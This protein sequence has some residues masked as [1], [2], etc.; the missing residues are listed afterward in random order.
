M[1]VRRSWLR[2]I[3]CGWPHHK[4]ERLWSATRDIHLP[5]LRIHQVGRYAGAGKWYGRSMGVPTTYTSPIPACK[6]YKCTAKCGVRW[7][8]ALR[9]AFR[10]FPSCPSKP[11]VLVNDHVSNRRCTL[12]REATAVLFEPLPCVPF[13]ETITK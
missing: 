10:T 2:R 4:T 6:V 7:F 3:A 13:T 12:L 5:Q 1:S 9:L 11:L 8:L